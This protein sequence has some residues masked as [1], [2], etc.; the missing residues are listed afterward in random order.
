VLRNLVFVLSITA[1]I[2]VAYLIATHR[3]FYRLGDIIQGLFFLGYPSLVLYY[4]ITAKPPSEKPK[5]VTYLDLFFE[6]RRLE[7]QAKIDK[8]RPD[9]K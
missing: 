8:L 2:V 3:S 4:V 5:I 1:I 6:R 7:E 9:T